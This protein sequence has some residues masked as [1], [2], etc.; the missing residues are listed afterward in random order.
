M[1]CKTSKSEIVKMI[2]NTILLRLLMI[3]VTFVSTNNTPAAKIVVPTQINKVENTSITAE[4]N[5]VPTHN[6]FPYHY[7][8]LQQQ[9]YKLSS[10]KTTKRRHRRHTPFLPGDHWKG[11]RPDFGKTETSIQ[12]MVNGTAKMKCPITHVSDNR[13]SLDN[14]AFKLI[15]LEPCRFVL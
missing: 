3:C 13:V 4:I 9:K 1:Q 6:V 10:M 15:Y 11:L 2:P 14:S 5:F 7:S 8:N 12:V